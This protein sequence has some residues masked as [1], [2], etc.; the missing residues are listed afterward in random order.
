MCNSIKKF[1]EWANVCGINP[2]LE[3]ISEDELD[4]VLQTFYC[5]VRR[6]DGEN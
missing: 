4:G 6:R 3:E 1:S 5:E 2:K